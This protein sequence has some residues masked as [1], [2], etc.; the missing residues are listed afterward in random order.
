MNERL[1][2]FLVLVCMIIIIVLLGMAMAHVML[3]NTDGSRKTTWSEYNEVVGKT[4]KWNGSDIVVTSIGDGGAYIIV[5]LA[6]NPQ[7]SPCSVRADR[8][9]IYAAYKASLG[10]EK[11]KQSLRE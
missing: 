9:P 10:V 8:D 7:Q 2:G 3:R 11:P 6:A 4:F 5:I 1:G